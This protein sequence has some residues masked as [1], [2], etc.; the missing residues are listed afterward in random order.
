MEKELDTIEKEL[1]TKVLLYKGLV[2]CL[3]RERQCL[4][5]I[6]MEQL[7]H[8]AT[9][10]QALASDIHKIRKSLLEHLCD[11]MPELNMDRKEAWLS[12]VSPYIPTD[13]LERLKKLNH[14]LMGLKTETKIRSHENI[15]IIE[16]SIGIL[17][18]IISVITTAGRSEV[19]YNN[20]CFLNDRSR[21]NMLLHREV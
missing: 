6:D 15:R 9:E 10:K 7:W 12:Q 20:E 1:Q 11:M 18:E 13:Y 5:H 21:D 14:S 17:D 16:D 3:K 2:E 19:T 8:I 4:I